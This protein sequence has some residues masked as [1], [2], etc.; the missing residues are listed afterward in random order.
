MHER[1]HLVSVNT[2]LTA[3]GLDIEVALRLRDLGGRWLA[4]A[5]F[6]GEPEVGIGP[7]PRVALTAALSSLGDRAATALMA[8]PQLL[9]VS[10]AIR[11]PA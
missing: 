2:R 9:A 7:T 6:D 11:R 5:E 3:E 1:P 8:D 10:T 4:V